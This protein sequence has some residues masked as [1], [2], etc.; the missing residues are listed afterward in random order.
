MSKFFIERPILANVIAIV[1]VVLGAVCLLR[2]P[3]AE[4]PN[5][6]PPTIQV[7]TNYPGASAEVVA[8]TV[9]IPIEQLINGVENSIYMQSTSGSDGSYTLTI[10]FAVGTD[11]DTSLALVQNAANGALSQLPQPVQAQGV[12]VRKVSTNILLIESLYSDEDRFD[13]PFLSNYALINLQNPIARLPGVGQVQVLGAGPY[14]MRIWVDPQK[15]MAFGLTVLDVQ[16]AIQSQNLQVAA[17]QLGGP[18]VPQDQVFQFTV[19][20]LG[21]LSDVTQFE[22]IIVKGRPPSTQVAELQQGSTETPSSA[23]VRVKDVARVELSQQVYSIFSRL[24]GKKAAHIAVFALPGANALDVASDVRELMASMRASFPAG[25]QHTSLYDTTLF[26]NQSIDA[27]YQTLIA[28]GVLVLIVIMLFLQNFRATLVPA[29]TVP[30]TIIGAFAAMAL[31]GFSVNLMT[32]FALIL[33]IGIVV[34]D[35]IVIVENASHHIE[36]GLAPREAAI[37]A[38]RELTGP[39]LGITLVLVSVFLPASF[40]PGITGQMFR[41]FALVIAATAIISA[42]NALTL[43]PTQ[44][45]LYL[46]AQPP[47]RRVNWLY[48]GFNAVYAALER[49]YVAL[50]RRMVRRPRLMVAV[51]FALIA[52]GTAGF[53]L[54]PTALVPL[55]DQGYCV[56]IA[57]LPPGAAQPRVRE[58]ASSIDAVLKEAPGIKGWVTIGGYSALD[59]AKLSNMATVFAIYEDWDKRPA[60]LSQLQIL[61]DLQRRFADIEKAV[62]AV[63]PPSP[64][65]GLGTAFGF[66]MMVED[67]GGAGLAEL[68]KIVREI[69]DEAQAKPGFLRLA[70]TTF[71]ADSPQLYLDIDRI[72]AESLGVPVNEVFQTLQTYLGSA[73]VNQFNKFNQSFQVRLQAGADHRRGLNDIGRLYVANDAGQMVPLGALL[74]VRRTLGS[75][76]ITRYNLYPSGAITGIPMPRFSS[77]QAMDEMERLASALLPAGMAYDWTGLSYQEQ[78]VGGQVYLIFALSILLVFLVLAAQ[79]ESWSDPITVVLTVPMAVLGIVLALLVRRFP[80]TLY[81]QIGLVLI[82]AL[83]AKNA[84]LIVEFARQLRRE[85]LAAREAAVEA[86]RRRFRPILMTSM[87]FILGVVPLLTASG[88]G[89]ASQQAIG[90]VVFGGMIASTLFALPFVPVFYV[91]IDELW[92]AR[93]APVSAP[94]GVGAAA[95]DPAAN[96]TPPPTA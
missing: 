85:G 74:N 33:A 1:T 83:A 80:I 93:P 50:V 61:A 8:T 75:E 31:L 35:A 27:V 79:Y 15:L 96:P 86:L 40:L 53:A 37:E 84:I 6:V 48:R 65:P 43:K 78:L 49:R 54:Y 34:D 11:L 5:I 71:R 52:A 60:G 9:G 19:N 4:Y 87:A 23:L 92:G 46:R 20:A 30:V 26:I 94:L 45:A 38:M 59:S 18:P 69:L 90:T 41:Q 68:Q 73:Y 39:V 81:T 77:G 44:C 67:R 25:L 7:S 3:V 95:G 13:E 56:I 51:F 70:F 21:R 57:Q 66:Q 2:L 58:V 72:M 63:L 89:A 82:I 28:A 10:T 42:L 24:N 22:N 12:N 55:E 88:A 32:L 64:I 14:S 62:F 76:L 47:N 91:A 16:N 17:G 29:T 36:R